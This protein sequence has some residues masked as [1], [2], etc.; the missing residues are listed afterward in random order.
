MA[1]ASSVLQAIEDDGDGKRY[2]TIDEDE[3][4]RFKDILDSGERGMSGKVQEDGWA[5]HLT[6]KSPEQMDSRGF[7]HMG[8]ATEAN[9]PWA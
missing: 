2:W 7:E 6:A 4:E 9:L 1:I 5:Y 3:F 8:E